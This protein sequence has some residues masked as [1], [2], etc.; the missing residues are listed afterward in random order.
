L[1]LLETAETLARD[2]RATEYDAIFA[3]SIRAIISFYRGQYRDTWQ[4]ADRA[5]DRLHQLQHGS[6]WEDPPWQMW[7]LIGLAL[8]GRIKELVRRV[9]NAAEDAALREDRYIEQ[10]ISLGP[11]SLA[12]L[13]MD[14]PEEALQRADR[15]LGWAPS[16]YTVQHYQHYVSTVD[17]DLYLGNPF[18]AWERTGRTWPAHERESFLL[19]TFV[20]DDLLRARGRSALA[21]ALALKQLGVARTASGHNARQLLA[22]AQR[23]V[24]SMGKRL[25]SARGFAALLSAGL[26]NSTGRVDE[27]RQHLASAAAAFDAAEMRLFREVVRCCA[28]RLDPGATGQS[29][30]ARAESWMQEEGVVMPA[31]IVAALAPGLPTA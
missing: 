1:S 18:S 29:E 16:A 27:A 31:R 21:A 12:W 24:R 10:N 2:E 26:A 23:A 6:T 25:T 28:G 13:V 30:L 5:L 14:R 22:I 17:C 11:P 7:S 4:C 20:G 15:A 8:N 3:Q 9:R 19:V